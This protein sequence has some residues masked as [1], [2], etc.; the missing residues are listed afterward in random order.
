MGELDDPNR[1]Q[2][3]MEWTRQMMARH[4]QVSKLADLFGGEIDRPSQSNYTN[5]TYG[6]DPRFQ[7][8]S[9]MLSKIVGAPFYD[10]S[11]LNP[12]QFGVTQNPAQYR[13]IR[14]LLPQSGGDYQS[15][16]DGRIPGYHE[17]QQ[18]LLGEMIKRGYPVRGGTG[19]LEGF[20]KGFNPVG[21]GQ[22][23][24]PNVQYGQ[25]GEVL[26]QG[27]DRSEQDDRFRAQNQE[28]MG[29]DIVG[30]SLL[31]QGLRDRLIEWNRPK[32]DTRSLWE[33][34]HNLPGPIGFSERL[35]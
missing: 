31:Q 17:L 3:V 9:S 8:F 21:F 26:R 35:R 13:G 4:A 22:R 20:T 27:S 23:D 19:Q 2:R 30:S 24:E 10:G 14:M 34:F 32:A 7:Q 15:L 25:H 6:G 16:K 5:P 18:E 12:Q 1:A 28:W 29:H 33:Q 11:P